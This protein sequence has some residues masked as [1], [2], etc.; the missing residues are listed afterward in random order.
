MT[1]EQMQQL[2]RE[3]IIELLEAVH[4]NDSYKSICD[5]A[6]ERGHKL[7]SSTLYAIT[8]K[9][10]YPNIYISAYTAYALA[11]LYRQPV[12]YLLGCE[13]KPQGMFAKFASKIFG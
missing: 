2:A 11:D 6:A 5:R 8:N 7:S 3:R 1:T 13:D 4:I 12:G 10:R 9:E